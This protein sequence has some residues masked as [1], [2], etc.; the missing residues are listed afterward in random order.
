MGALHPAFPPFLRRLPSRL[1]LTLLWVAMLLP[2]C[3]R[4]D[5]G[6]TAWSVRGWRSDTGLPDDEDYDIAQ[7]PDGCIWIATSVGPFRFDGIQFTLAD[8]PEVSHDF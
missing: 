4:A 6:E 8:V 5:Q 3:A 1:A 7:G 2:A